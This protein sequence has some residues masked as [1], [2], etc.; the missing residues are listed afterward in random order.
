M[1]MSTQNFQ[2]TDGTWRSVQPSEGVHWLSAL[3]VPWWVAGGWA[4][5]LFV[6]YQSRLHKDFD[7]GILRRDVLEVIAELPSWEFFEAKG[8][9]LTKLEAGKA[10]RAGV[11]SLWGRAADS[12]RWELELMLDEA[13]DDHWVFRRAPTIRRPLTTAIRH[14]SDGIPYLAPEIQLLYKARA[15]RAQ[16][17]TDF[18]H[19]APRLDLDARGW[20]QDALAKTDPGHTWLSLLGAP[21]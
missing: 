4:L 20:L 15:P 21:A 13:D 16:D 2:S 17:Q 3:S 18:V 8:G 11:N 19:I 9:V 5:D 7:V 1:R 6:G 10:P 14:N 12:V